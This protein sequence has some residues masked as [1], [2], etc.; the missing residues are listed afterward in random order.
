[1]ERI[2]QFQQPVSATATE[3]Q[4]LLELNRLPCGYAA[5]K[6]KQVTWRNRARMSS[7]VMSRTETSN[8][9]PLSYTTTHTHMRVYEGLPEWAGTSKVKPIWILLKQETVNGSGISWAICKSAPHSRQITTPAPHHSVF[10]RPHALPATQPTASKHWRG[11]EQNSRKLPYQPWVPEAKCCVQ[12]IANWQCGLQQMPQIWTLCQHSWSERLIV[13][14][15]LA[16]V[17]SAVYLQQQRNTATYPV[18]SAGH[19]WTARFLTCWAVSPRTHQL[20]LPS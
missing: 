4:Q 5:R 19:T 20:Y 2:N 17:S 16:F 13:S 12:P 15:S 8:N 11:I 1:M 7:S 9:V 14:T 3:W 18:Q 10:Y 6:N